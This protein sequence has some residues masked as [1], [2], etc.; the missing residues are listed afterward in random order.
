M[1]KLFA[2][3]ITRTALQAMTNGGVTVPAEWFD[4]HIPSAHGRR[5]DIRR[6]LL[7]EDLDYAAHAD[8][9]TALADLD[10]TPYVIMSNEDSLPSGP[11]PAS[12]DWDTPVAMHCVDR[13]FEA[14]CNQ[15]AAELAVP[16][17]VVLAHWSAVRLGAR[18]ALDLVDAPAEF[19]RAYADGLSEWLR[20]DDLPQVLE[21]LGEPQ[22]CVWPEG[23]RF[24]DSD[25]AF[26]LA[27]LSAA[28]RLRDFYIPLRALPCC[29]IGIH[30]GRPTAFGFLLEGPDGNWPFD[31]GALRLGL[32]RSMVPALGPMVDGWIRLNEARALS[33]TTAQAH[34]NSLRADTS[35][36]RFAFTLDLAKYSH[37][38]LGLGE[39]VPYGARSPWQMLYLHVEPHRTDPMAGLVMRVAGRVPPSF[40]VVV[41]LR[42]CRTSVLLVEALFA[43]GSSGHAFSLPQDVATENVDIQVLMQEITR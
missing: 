40:S 21:R 15:V 35:R 8:W 2:Y 9:V 7:I 6:F 3:A 43:T 32:L 23:V 26:G 4:W 13:R 18:R 25:F 16:D 29:G 30:Q 19:W 39:A 5:M 1:S 24:T 17:Q 10:V 14:E 34:G 11:W 22:L 20:A 28:D 33:E 42:D 36:S 27:E 38:V 12:D 37:Q 41:R 31:S